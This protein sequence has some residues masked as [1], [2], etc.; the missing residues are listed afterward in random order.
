MS[1]GAATPGLTNENHLS[2]N[3]EVKTLTKNRTRRRTSLDVLVAA[4]VPALLAATVILT[5]ILTQY[6]GLIAV[7]WGNRAIYIDGRPTHIDPK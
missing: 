3:K 1:P 7:E 4:A 5:A 6:P 2:R